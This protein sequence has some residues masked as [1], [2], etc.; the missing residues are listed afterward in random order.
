M[1]FLDLAVH[2]GVATITI[3]R[4]QSGNALNW[5]LLEQLRGAILWATDSTS[6]EAIVIAALGK[7][8]VSGADV[9]FFVRC[10]ESGDIGR[11]VECIRASQE[12][13]ATIAACPKPV[14]AAVHAAAVGGGV[15]LALA[16][17][18]IIA[19][20]RAIFSLPETALGIIPFSGGTYRLPRRV[21]V[22]LAKWLIYTSH[23]LPPPKA[24]ALGLCDQLV[25]PE[26]LAAAATQTA[27]ALCGAD[28]PALKPRTA[29]L[30]P[31][32]AWFAG[33]RVADL[34]VADVPRIA[35][36]ATAWKALRGRSLV[37]LE[38][39]EMLLDTALDCTLQQGASAALEAVPGLFEYPDV[40]SLLA[41]VVE[42][43]RGM[44]GGGP[45][46]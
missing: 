20:P 39:A 17:H 11:I 2:E 31:W 6:V 14:V 28:S 16:C 41:R 36:L 15:E 29:A 30:A 32:D 18:R 27:R 34:R 25:M 12:V 24:L 35:A 9:G 7:S 23:L 5:P 19:T 26:Q 10:L 45:A 1:P 40:H 4:P 33:A 13:F 44:T 22:P 21:G 37:A 42:R 43:Q 38:R 3:N 8:F 46:V